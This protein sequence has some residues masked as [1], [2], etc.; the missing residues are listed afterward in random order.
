MG[1]PTAAARRPG[2]V[3]GGS[4]T[5]RRLRPPR[6]RPTTVRGQLVAAARTASRR[7]ASQGDAAE[8]V[9]APGPLRQP[10]R[11][12]LQQV[13]LVQGEVQPVAGH[14]AGVLDVAHQGVV[15]G[16]ERRRAREPRSQV[17]VAR[18]HRALVS[19][20]PQRADWPADGKGKMSVCVMRWSNSTSACRWRPS[21]W[22]GARRAW[23]C[24]CVTVGDRWGSCCSS[25]RSDDWRRTC[26]RT[27][28]CTSLQPGALAAARHT[29]PSAR[30]VAAAVTPAVGDLLHPGA[31]F[32]ADCPSTRPSPHDRLRGASTCSSPRCGTGRPWSAGC[33]HRL[34]QRARQPS[35]SARG[36]GRTA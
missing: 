28:S 1:E 25:R 2:R 13:E 11:G 16:C 27:W 9:G 34:G 24:C 8:P 21:T 14:A 4:A 3:T 19:S 20:S 5:G 22:T 18:C 26:W 12:V 32:A 36:T 7:D 33:L 17:P 10:L 29:G 35:S 15:D 6:V 30:L 23:A 31:A